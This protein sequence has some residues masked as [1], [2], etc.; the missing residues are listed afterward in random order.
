MQKIRLMAPGPGKCP[1]CAGRHGAKEPHAAESF[2]YMARF[3]RR[4]GRFPTRED[5]AAD[6]GRS[7]EESAEA[8]E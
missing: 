7:A 6:A 1:V 4:C 8:G 3:R 5:A 2:Y